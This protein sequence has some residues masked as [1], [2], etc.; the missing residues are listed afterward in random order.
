VF[1][2]LVSYFLC[3]SRNFVREYRLKV[4]G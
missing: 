3:V 4:M 1:F 2:V